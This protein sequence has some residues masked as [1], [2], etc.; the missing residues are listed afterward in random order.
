M[1]LMI[2]GIAYLVLL[3]GLVRFFQ[4]VH[5]C[6]EQIERMTRQKEY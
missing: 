6:D 3:V 2:A 4:T 1:I 5:E